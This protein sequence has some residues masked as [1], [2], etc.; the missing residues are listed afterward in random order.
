VNLDDLHGAGALVRKLTKD[1]R[2][3][4]ASGAVISPEVDDHRKIALQNLALE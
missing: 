1:G 3:L 2:D 4:T